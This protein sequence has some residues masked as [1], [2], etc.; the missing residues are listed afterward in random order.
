M[1]IQIPPS[2]GR[3]GPN[4][5]CTSKRN[6]HLMNNRQVYGPWHMWCSDLIILTSLPLPRLRSNRHQC[7]E[8]AELPGWYI[9]SNEIFMLTASI[10][11]AVLC[12]AQL[13]VIAIWLDGSVC[14]APT[15]YCEYIRCAYSRHI[16]LDENSHL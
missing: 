15:S 12:C 11:F 6:K 13:N 2:V 4:N 14:T 7:R 9:K 3:Q 8:T 16:H 10:V 1:L 5:P